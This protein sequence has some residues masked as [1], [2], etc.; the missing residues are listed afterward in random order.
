MSNLLS[1]SDTYIVNLISNLLLCGDTYIVDLTYNYT[2]F[3]SGVDTDAVRKAVK[4]ND[5]LLNHLLDLLGAAE[6][7]ETT[8]IIVVGDH[9]MTDH[10]SNHVI[11]LSDYGVQLADLLWHTGTFFTTGMLFPREDKMDSVS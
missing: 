3:R 9:G 7:F 6:I 4:Q 5:L 8:N 2:Y 11:Y 1:C 10:D